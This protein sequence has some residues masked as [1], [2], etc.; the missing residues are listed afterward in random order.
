MIV[1]KIDARANETAPKIYLTFDD[2]PDRES[3]PLVL[4]V[5][6]AKNVRST[7][8]AIAEKAR[9]NPELIRRIIEEGHSIGNHSIDHK[10]GVFF[11]GRNAMLKWIDSS[12]AL[13]RSI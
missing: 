9:E 4:D 8:F 12:E 10:Y 7:F 1:R 11:K 5:L 3:T 2:G 13:Y 6:R